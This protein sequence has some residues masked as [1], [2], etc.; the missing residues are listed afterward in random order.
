MVGRTAHGPAVQHV[1][2]V[3]CTDSDAQHPVLVK[4]AVHPDDLGAGVS[5][6]LIRHGTERD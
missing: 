4:R 6:A 3:R 2:S 5:L 1:A